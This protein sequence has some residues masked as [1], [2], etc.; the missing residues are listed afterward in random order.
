MTKTMHSTIDRPAEAAPNF[1]DPTTLPNEYA[2]RG[3]CL[4]PAIK[5]D[6]AVLF[7][8]RQPYAAGDLVGVYLKPGCHGG[9]TNV[10]LNRIVMNMMPGVPVVNGDGQVCGMISQA[11]IARHAAELVRDEPSAE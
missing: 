4:A 10:G 8:Q 5:A 7:D 2:M 11:Y 6:D 3:D 9:S 1:I